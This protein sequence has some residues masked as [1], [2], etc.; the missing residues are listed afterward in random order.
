MKRTLH[1][2]FPVL[3]LA[4]CLTGCEALGVTSGASGGEVSSILQIQQS[5]AEVVSTFMDA[6]GRRDY[7]A[8]YALLA[9]QSQ[10]LTSPAVF[11]EI[12]E[13]ADSAIGTNAV[14][15]TITDTEEQGTSAVVNYDAVIG[16]TIFGELPDNER[17]M[18]LVET[19]NGWRIAWTQMDIFDGYAP[20]TTLD[21]A[22]RRQPR[23]NIY[24]SDGQPL[25]EQDGAVVTV[26]VAQNAI[27]DYE[28]C[29]DV[30][31]T[32][33][34]RQRGDLDEMFAGY[35]LET[36]IP[37]GDLDQEGYAR[38]S[39]SLNDNCAAVITTRET[40]RYAGHGAAAHITGYIGGI[41]S[42][43]VEAYQSRGY[44]FG[45]LVG[46]GG[47]E[48]QYEEELAGGATRVLRIIEP[49]GMVVR[50]LASSEGS[51]PMD[52]NLTIDYNLQMTAGQALS[53]AF[54]YAEGNWGS[55]EHSTGAG[56]VVMDV[57]TGAVLALASYPTYDPG[58][59]NPDTPYFF[60]GDYII[61]LGGDNRQP[62]L[63]RVIQNS[64]PPGSTFKI[65]T[66]AAAA[67]EGIWGPEEIFY[68]G[69]V[70]QGQEYGDT[71]PERYD[72][73]NFE[74]EEANFDTGDVNMP[75]ALT[76]SCNPFFYTMGALLYRDRGAST[77]TNYA[78]QMGLGRPTGIDI[79]VVPEAA[80]QIPTPQGADAAISEA[81]GQSDVQVTLLQMARMVSGVANGGTLYQPYIVES[82]GIDG[83]MPF[84]EAE[85]EIVGDMGL[86]EEALAVVRQGM[87]QVTD[88]TVYGRTSGE[89]LGTAWF[90]FTDPDWYP[91][92]YTVCGK[93]G[94]AQTGRIE[95][96]GW[97]V[98]FA[99]ADD[100]Q[101]AIAGMVEY[102]REGSETAAPIV[103]RILDAYF[104]VPSDQVAPYPDWWYE[105]DYAPLTIPEGSTGV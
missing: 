21:A 42:E 26:Y 14:T 85:P 75:D 67:N 30:L 68:C 34:M 22:S 51:T 7:D 61:E 77:L 63:N 66:T 82:V 41:P 4:G 64:Y 101:I 90:V 17:V 35:N 87:C 8:M 29:L 57:D 103:R 55:R 23:G 89:R 72:W 96:H 100:P 76:A 28:L 83:Q 80:G 48:A 16:S 74:P 79:E 94:T 69:R 44:D 46:L 78:R 98:A 19:A 54:N 73:R 36:Q 97:F 37:I 24:A 70:W 6:W 2:L 53:D 91:V 3:I 32:A 50:E 39:Q 40:R 1:F 84:Y 59:F 62:F 38:Y 65:I 105:N 95:P 47:L 33:F 15:A 92:S 49:G 99:P 18:R 43:Q 104:N 58:I 27:F 9:P 31:T 71:R 86:S 60:V 56:V 12:Y 20:G 45:E 88:S 102:G 11:R 13:A 52:V 10:Q 25:V 5:P 93:T 81:I